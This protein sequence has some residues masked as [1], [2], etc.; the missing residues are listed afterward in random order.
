VRRSDVLADGVAL[1]L[2][3]TCKYVVAVLAADKRGMTAVLYAARMHA[4]TGPPLLLMDFDAGPLRAGL[5]S[6]VNARVLELARVCKAAGAAAF[7]P[8][9]MVRHAAA[10]GLLAEGIPEDLQAEGL[11][12]SVAQHIASGSV[13]ICAPA[14]DKAR[15]SPF[16]SALDFRASENADDPLRSAALLTIALALDVN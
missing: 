7:V 2:P 1:P 11:L 16:G 10:G 14:M 5:F 9:D 3:A 13:K 4:G 8:A 12:V 6:S 15:T